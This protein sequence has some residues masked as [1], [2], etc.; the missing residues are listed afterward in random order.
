[1]STEAP[2][3]ASNG[4]PEVATPEAKQEPTEEQE[5]PFSWLQPH[6]TFAIVLVGTE[7]KPFG[8]Q[9][10]FLCAK[11]K[12]YHDYFKGQNAASEAIENVVKLPQ[13]TP[14]VF[15]LA[16][17]FLFTGEVSEDAETFPS[18]E[19]LVGVWKLGHELGI[20]GLCDTSLDA[21]KECRRLT[22][23]IPATPLL[24]QVWKDTPEGST[25]RKLLLSWAAEYMRSSDKKAE[26]AKSLPQEVLSEL[27]VTMSSLEN[28][29]TPPAAPADTASAEP[30]SRKSV[31]YLEEDSEEEQEHMSKKN[32]RA[33]AP[34][35]ASQNRDKAFSRAPPPPVRK[36][37]AV[38]AAASAPRQK[39]V[40]QKRRSIAPGPSGEIT[41]QQKVEFCSDLLDRMLSGPG[42]W[43]RLV[44]PFKEPVDPAE[45]GV[46][47]YFDKVKK[48]MDLNTVKLKMSQHQ[49]QTEDEFAADVR[50]IFENCYTY[51]KKGD[52][53][54]A[55]CEKFQRTFEDKYAQMHKNISKMLREPVD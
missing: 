53:M 5:M 20:D 16:Q 40:I 9:R 15:G 14:E 3:A 8:L 19:A 30:T 39:P 38:A 26:F 48:P 23:N 13:Y 7:Q 43:T 35:P 41:T 52:P 24:V 49:Y 44:G 34:L 28:L 27:V 1:M 25:I 32:R 17:L 46:P 22:Q 37:A 51:W 10:D 42:F 2:V 33:S 4:I 54:W 11:S 45:D 21:M 55:A 18:Y 31:H 29:P 36:A 12:Y 6:S 47:D 50:Q